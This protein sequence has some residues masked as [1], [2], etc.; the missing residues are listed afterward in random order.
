M[1]PGTY[2]G[3]SYTPRSPCGHGFR[4]FSGRRSVVV[5]RVDVDARDPFGPEHGQV[6]GVVL[7]CQLDVPPG[8]PEVPDAVLLE[9]CRPAV[10]AV[11]AH[12]EQVPAQPVAVQP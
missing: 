6:A 8:V 2:N 10:V 12:D 5:A 7:E 9:G 3:R 1:P 11:R 4:R